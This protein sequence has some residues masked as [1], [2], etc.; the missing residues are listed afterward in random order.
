MSVSVKT[1]PNG[2]YALGAEIDGQWVPFV[3]LSGA[4]VAGRVERSRNLAE[5][6]DQGNE[7]AAGVLFASPAA[8]K[9]TSGQ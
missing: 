1:N 8:R 7:S 5:Q 2:D 9:G 4:T 3:I 6:A